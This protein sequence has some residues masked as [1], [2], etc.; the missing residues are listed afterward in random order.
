MLLISAEMAKNSNKKIHKRDRIAYP[1]PTFDTSVDVQVLHMVPRH[2]CHGPV[3]RLWKLFLALAKHCKNLVTHIS[4]N[5]KTTN[6]KYATVPD[7][8]HYYHQDSLFMQIVEPEEIAYLFK[9]RPAKNFG[10]DFVSICSE[11]YNGLLLN[12]ESNI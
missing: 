5:V 8:S 7:I 4:S 10:T 9:V 6:I 11:L 1:G 2:L 12:I 3:S